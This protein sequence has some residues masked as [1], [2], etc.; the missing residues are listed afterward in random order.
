[1]LPR[2]VSTG[3]AHDHRRVKQ[4]TRGEL[5][6]Q[7]LQHVRPVRPLKL[8]PLHAPPARLWPQPLSTNVAEQCCF[9]SLRA[10]T[11]LVALGA[12]RLWD[13]VMVAHGPK[14]H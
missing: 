5:T 6:Q 4:L 14:G 1:M 11:L 10:R 3:S 13:L 9:A 8:P 2:V 12:E 7:L